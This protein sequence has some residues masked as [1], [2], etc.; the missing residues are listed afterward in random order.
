MSKRLYINT[1]FENKILKANGNEFEDFFSEIMKIINGT[2]F[3]QIKPCGQHGDRK[4]D[5]Y[6]Y[7][8]GKFFQV[9]CPE[10]LK[11]AST[12]TYAVNKL[13]DNFR[14]LLKH[15]A[16]E[17][18]PPIKHFYYVINDKK[19][20]VPPELAKKRDELYKEFG[21]PIDFFTVADL[22]NVFRKLDE[23]EKEVLLSVPIPD[24]IDYSI[25]SFAAL[26]EAVEY[27]INLDP[28]LHASSEKL[29]VPDFEEKLIF[30][31]LNKKSAA[32]F[33][34]YSLY[35][36]EI[37]SFFEEDPQDLSNSLREKFSALYEE[38]K[39][40][41][42]CSNEHFQYIITN[43]IDTSKK[44]NSQLTNS[45]LYLMSYFFASCDIFEEPK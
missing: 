28:I 9:Y 42:S 23:E 45:V 31:N 22:Q 5:G 8:N 41:S 12:I 38:A 14:G 26:N 7:N 44:K 34:N 40:I 1:Y 21:I 20:G 43:S 33:N 29:I 36:D 2:N 17:N 15:H 30:N 10:D 27:I 32:L 3:T 24:K 39:A 4:N 6:F 35:H 18:W 11:K 19:S 16:E 25:V 37:D 13:D